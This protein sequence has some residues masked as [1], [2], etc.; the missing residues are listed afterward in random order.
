MD[1]EERAVHYESARILGDKDI[2]RTKGRT[3]MGMENNTVWPQLS[4]AY[5]L[6]ISCAIQE[7][8]LSKN[9]K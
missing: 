7:L 1:D 2:N 8:N 4:K 3:L 9:A 6:M 5:F